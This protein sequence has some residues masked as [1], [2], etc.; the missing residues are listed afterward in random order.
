MIIK[1]DSILLRVYL[2][3]GVCAAIAGIVALA[4]LGAVSPTFGYQNEFMAIAAAVLG[5]TSLFGGKGNIPG[6]LLGAL[7]I[8]SIQNGLVIVNA[9]PYFYPVITS[10]VIFLIVMIDSL[11]HKRE[12]K[13]MRTKITIDP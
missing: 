3:S 4:Q 5:G 6:T 8:Q 9:D 2:I 13:E 1:V 12:L 7:L 11:R 10:L